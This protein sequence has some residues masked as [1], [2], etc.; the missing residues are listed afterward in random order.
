MKAKIFFMLLF[1]S[2]IYKAQTGVNTNSPDPSVALDIQ[3]RK[4]ICPDIAT[5]K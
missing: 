3:G 4:Y 1:S 5:A 2:I